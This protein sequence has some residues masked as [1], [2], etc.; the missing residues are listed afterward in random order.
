MVGKRYFLLGITL[1][2]WF[3]YLLSPEVTFKNLFF[4]SSFFKVLIDSKWFD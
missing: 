3:S 2:K 4:G 1:L